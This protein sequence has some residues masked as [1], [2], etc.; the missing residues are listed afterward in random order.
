[1]PEATDHDRDVTSTM[2]GPVAAFVDDTFA[3]FDEAFAQCAGS[4]VHDAALAG[5]PIR[6]RYAAPSLAARFAPAIEHLRTAAAPAADLEVCCWDRSS[7]EVRAPAPPWSHDDLLPQGRVR[8]LVDG[9]VRATY[10]ATARVLCLYH[11]DRRAA[12][13]H[14]ADADGVPHWMDRAPFRTVLT[15]WAADRGLALLHASAVS[16]ARGA[17]VLAGTSGAGKST[18]ALTCVAAGMGFLGDDACAV[19]YEP[20]PTVHSVYRFA[21]VE[22]GVAARLD[23]H[24]DANL[25]AHLERALPWITEE[26]VVD[27]GARHRGRAP[28]RAILLPQIVGGA[29]SGTVPVTPAQALAVLGPTTLVEGGA[30]SRG[31]LRALLDLVRRVP[32]YRLE[33]GT[34]PAGVVRSV[35]HVL[36]QAA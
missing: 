16:T 28:L 10:D 12:V 4:V 24:L 14:V 30:P 13:V 18:T 5:H 6:V 19:S 20:A 29:A 36:E 21:K 22:R 26:V 1:L 35:E 25:D 34:D 2:D 11:A 27:A 23:G 3:A 17:V 15:W 7:T 32:A 9:R 33:L 8:G 31:A